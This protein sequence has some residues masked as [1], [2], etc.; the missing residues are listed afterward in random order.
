ML[1]ALL[2]RNAP[3]QKP[4]EEVKL[5]YASQIARRAADLRHREQPARRRAR[6]VP[7]LPGARLPRGLAVHR[8]AA[9]AQVH[10]RADRSADARALPVA[11]RLV[12]ARRDSDQLPGGAAVRAASICGSTAAGISAPPISTGCWAGG[13]PFRSGCST[14][15]RGGPGAGVRAAG[16]RLRAV[17]AGLRRWRR[18]LGHVFSV[19]VRLQGR[20]GRGDRGGRHARRSRPLALGVAALV[21]VVA[22]LCSPATSRSAASPPPPCSRWRCTCSSRPTQPEHALAR[23]R[24]SR[25][26]SSGS[27]ARISS[28]C[29]RAPRTGSAAGRRSARVHDRRSR[30][31]ARAA[32]A[33]RSP[34]CWRAKG[35]DG[36]ALGL[37]ARGG[38]GGQPRAREP[39]VPAGRA[40]RRRAPRVRRRARRRC[41]GAGDRVGAAEPRGARGGRRGSRA[42]SRR[43]RWW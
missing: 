23:R 33:R 39:A 35:D 22:G 6:V 8:L 21:W 29:S 43:A 38:R 3:P 2:E 32:G 10:R 24:W 11:A 31:W 30:S 13:T 40:A 16:L 36:P 15:P 14:P 37:R 42:R 4:G 20:E 41:R 9:A 34:T 17:R 5:L 18:S 1:T 28:G 19:F 12:P 26:R 7:A 27:T 25:R